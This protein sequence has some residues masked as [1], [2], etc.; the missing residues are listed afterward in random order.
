MY[1]KDGRYYGEQPAIEIAKEEVEEE[2]EKNKPKQNEPVKHFQPKESEQIFHRIQ[3]S[4][5]EQ[6]NEPDRPK[7][8]RRIPAAERVN[9]EGKK[10]EK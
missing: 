7:L 8:R 4:V 2:R 6:C 9:I 1:R 5:R 10:E 3:V